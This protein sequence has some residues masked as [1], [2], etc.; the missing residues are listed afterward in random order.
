MLDIFYHMSDIAVFICMVVFSIV[1]TL[2]SILISRYVIFYKLRYKDNTT[3]ASIAALLGIIYGVLVGFISLYLLTNQDHAS[4]A[5]LNEGIATANIYRDSQ[6]LKEP[7]RSKLQAILKQYIETAIT[8]EWRDMMDGKNPLD[9]NSYAIDQLSAVLQTYPLATQADVFVV[10][11]MLQEIKALFKGRQERIQMSQTQLSPEIWAVILLS[12]V[13]IIVINYAFR[14]SFYVH[15]F[16]ITVF[17][18]MAAS[19][20]FLLVTLDRPF[21]GEFNVKPTALQAVLA[22][23][24]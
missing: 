11:D 22:K 2:F 14:V 13:L 12:T 3:T 5:A 6:W 4:S 21:R 24:T 1:F 18:I 7:T 19:I 16:T 15:T 23:M 10:S 9:D 20:L 17:A 8:V